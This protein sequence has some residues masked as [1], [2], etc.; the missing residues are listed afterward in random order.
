MCVS[1]CNSLWQRKASNL[2]VRNDDGE[3]LNVVE[4]VT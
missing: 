3:E 1:A 4:M 2:P